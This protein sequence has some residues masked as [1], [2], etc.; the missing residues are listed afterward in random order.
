MIV[1]LLHVHI[2]TQ[3]AGERTAQMASQG[4]PLMRQ[5]PDHDRHKGDGL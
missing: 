1:M 5:R 4:G 3:G 2:I